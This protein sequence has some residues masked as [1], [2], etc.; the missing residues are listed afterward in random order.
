MITRVSRVI[1]VLIHLI[2]IR[3]QI[4]LHRVNDG[5]GIEHYDCVVVQPS[6]SYCRRPREL[7]D[8]FRDND[9]QSCVR[10]GGEMHRFS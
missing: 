7:I 4:Y 8:L 1:V 10:N 6:L 5:L 9:T 2:V 3:S